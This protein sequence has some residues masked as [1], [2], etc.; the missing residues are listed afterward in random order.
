MSTHPDPTTN[1]LSHWPYKITQGFGDI[2]TNIGF[3]RLAGTPKTTTH[4]ALGIRQ[5][6]HARHVLALE[7]IRAI[8]TSSK[9]VADLVNY[10][11]IEREL[12]LSA[13]E[14]RIEGV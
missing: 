14:T 12:S 8:A 5:A 3:G 6:K 13:A 11:R 7:A 9:K 2:Q 1:K 10:L 4:A